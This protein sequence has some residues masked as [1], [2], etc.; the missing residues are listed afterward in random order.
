MAPVKR[1]LLIDALGTMLWMRPPWEE[2]DPAAVRGVPAERV[3]AGFEAEIAYYMTHIAEGSDPEGLADLRRRCAAVLSREAGA[4]I[5]VG[6]MLA[7]IRFEPFDDAMPALE[8]ARARGLR[9]VC[10]SNWDCSLPEVL[11]RTG[12]AR[13]LDGVVS[14]ASSGARKPDPAI[15]AAGLRAAGCSA[16]QAL[17]V[18]DS[19]ED[20]AGARAAGIDVLR[21]SR[22]GRGGEGTIGSLSEIGPYL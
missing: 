8:E 6:A 19:D 2:I 22:D 14:S 9:L 21:I 15:F 16:E 18:G 13:L 11:E 17:H 3:R 7:A 10:V 20:V 12:L 1:A 5:P 4:E